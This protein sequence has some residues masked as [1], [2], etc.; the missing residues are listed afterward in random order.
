V[1]TAPTTADGAE[2]AVGRDHARRRAGG[3]D[4]APTPADEIRHCSRMAS[5]RPALSLDL[6]QGSPSDASS[7]PPKQASQPGGC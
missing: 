1:P 5:S 3:R 2:A 6:E 4:D 7:R